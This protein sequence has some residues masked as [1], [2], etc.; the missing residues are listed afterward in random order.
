MGG[1]KVAKEKQRKVIA[2]SLSPE[3]LAHVKQYQ[4]D[5]IRQHSYKITRN[6]AVDRLLLHFLVNMQRRKNKPPL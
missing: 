4:Q 2:V 5:F 3:A 1:P 6:E